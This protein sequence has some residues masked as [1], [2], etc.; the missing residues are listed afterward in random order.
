MGVLPVVNFVFMRYGREVERRRIA[1]APST[2][3]GSLKIHHKIINA[4]RKDGEDGVSGLHGWQVLYAPQGFNQDGRFQKAGE[5]NAYWVLHRESFDALES[6][7]QGLL[8]DS[9]PSRS[10]FLLCGPIGKSHWVLAFVNSLIRRAH[11]RLVENEQLKRGSEP[12]GK[13][14]REVRFRVVPVLDCRELQHNFTLALVRG[15]SIAFGDDQQA[16]DEICQLETA[17]QFRSF[18]ACQPA[19]VLFVLDQYECV[20]EP[21]NDTL[22][23]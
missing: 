15:L 6:E 1:V 10:S 2:T 5:A 4:G 12:A 14:G 20:L 16:L 13:T 11:D 17:K 23:G 19:R 18:V 7:V 22:K 3:L 9:R 8:F 21:G